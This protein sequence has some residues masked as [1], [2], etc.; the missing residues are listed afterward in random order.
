[1]IKKT[2]INNHFLC[3]LFFLSGEFYLYYFKHLRQNGNKEY[4]IKKQNL[5]CLID[6]MVNKMKLDE[7]INIYFC[8]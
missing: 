5:I 8:L 1:M 7:M 2:N 6:G 3:Y 4:R